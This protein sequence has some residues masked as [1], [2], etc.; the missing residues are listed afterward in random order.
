MQVLLAAVLV[1][2]FTGLALLHLY[3]GVGGRLASDGSVPTEDGRPLFEAGPLSC[4]AVAAAL[5]AAA[6]CC[7]MRTGMLETGMPD[8]VARVGT[9]VIA[10]VF[11][12]R[13]IGDLRYVGFFKRVRGTLFARRDSLVY[14][15]LALLIALFAAGLALSSPP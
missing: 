14:S 7:A 11:A 1:A 2:I 15:P 4:A 13:A 6:L 5:V 3:W 8:W 9:W 12:A 10:T